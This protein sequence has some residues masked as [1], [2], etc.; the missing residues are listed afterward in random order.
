MDNNNIYQPFSFLSEFPQ[1]EY[2]IK[3]KYLS[4][5]HRNYN[6]VLKEFKRNFINVCSDRCEFYKNPRIFKEKGDECINRDCNLQ[7]SKWNHRV[8]AYHSDYASSPVEF[9]YHHRNCNKKI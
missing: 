2:L 9:E 3:E 7:C 6:A 5:V 8:C 1:F 4:P